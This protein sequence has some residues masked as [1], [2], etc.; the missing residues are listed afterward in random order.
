MNLEQLEQ[1]KKDLKISIDKIIREEVEMIFLNELAQN[2]LSSKIAFYGG[3]ALRLVY[4]SPRFSEDIDLI[5]IK[6]ISFTEFKNF[7][8]D[9]SKQQGWKLSDIKD[10]RR[11]IF[12]LFKINDEKLKHPFSLKIEIHKPTKKVEL[13][14]NLNLIKSPVS[15]LSPLLLVPT[16]E[17]LK[18]LKENAIVQRKKARDIFDLWYISQVLR[19][20]FSLP[21]LT[22][23]FK[24]R[25]FKN[26]LQVF[27]PP[28][29]YPIIKQLYEQIIKRNK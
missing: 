13:N 6:K 21:S 2:D 12:A 20:N 9:I 22:P 24:E 23:S 3:T 25:A 7:I 26:E 27:L 17:N 11:T 5:E 16:L 8:E 18:V 1:Y 4:N 14:T 10:K 19:V 29:Y 28:K 15:I